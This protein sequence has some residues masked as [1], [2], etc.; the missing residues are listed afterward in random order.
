MNLAKVILVVD[1]AINFLSFSFD[2]PRI[3]VYNLGNNSD[4]DMNTFYSNVERVWLVKTLCECM[5]LLPL[6]CP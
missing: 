5:Y 3:S 2:T 6:N 1:I 4:K